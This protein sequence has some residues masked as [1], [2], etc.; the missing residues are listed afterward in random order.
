MGTKKEKELKIG[1][2]IIAYRA[3]QT[4]IS[5]YQRIPQT[6]KRKAKEIYCFDDCSDDNTYYAGLGYKVSHKIKNFILYKNPKN[7]GYGGNQKKGYRYAIK[8]KMDVVVMLHGDAQ[9]APEKMPL[10]LEPFQ[11]D[12]WSGIGV[13]M[14]SRMLGDPLQGGMPL[15]KYLGN[16]VLTFLEN[17]LLQSNLSEFHSG[18]RAYNLKA[19]ESIPF[20]KCSNDFNFDTDI[21][22]MLLKA[23]YKVVEVPIPTYYGPGSKSHVNVFKYGFQC[24]FSVINYRL[25]ELGL[26]KNSKFN[27]RH[28]ISPSY[29]YKD[30]PTSSH[31]QI[32]NL[33]TRLK[34]FNV[35]DLGCGGGFVR[36]AMSNTKGYNFTGVE[37]DT[38]WK[39]KNEISNGYNKI[40]W[41]D[42]ES[43]KWIEELNEDRFDLVVCADVLE[44]LHYPD[45][46]LIEIKKFLKK[47]GKIIVSLPNMDYLPVLIIRL[48]FPKFRM[49]KG[50]LDRTHIG[51][52]NYDVSKRLIEQ[53]YK[54]EK[55]NVTPL[56]LPSLLGGFEGSWWGKT[57]HRTGFSLAKI[58]PRL[59]AYQFIFLAKPN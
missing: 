23:G 11:A 9:Y 7:L 14:G 15:Y 22:I 20:E 47:D 40:V 45:V 53:G 28:N 18:Y 49:S 34:K 21:I 39:D 25:G 35:L 19:L 55:V 48:I 10:L 36:R 29:G 1:V 41:S 8:K 57:L 38:F 26:K 32:A 31:G 54:I 5:A 46:T 4:L 37:M 44:H 2:F 50:P 6:L 16:K 56:P 13:V 33:I 52:Y 30:D 17:F 51:I 42:L 59:F 27:F 3:A 43:S 24:L 58:A 12:D